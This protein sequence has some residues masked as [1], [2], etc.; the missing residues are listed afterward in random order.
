MTLK[1]DTCCF[2]ARHLTLLGYGK[3]G[4]AQCQDNVTEWD[5]RQPGLPV[6]HHYKVTVRVH[7]N[8]SVPSLI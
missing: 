8:K 4:L 3:D 1:I 6:K 2:L 5:I 7:G